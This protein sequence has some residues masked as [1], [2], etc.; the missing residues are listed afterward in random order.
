[1]FR[2]VLSR[3]LC[4]VVGVAFFGLALLWV[5]SLAS[6]S[7]H[8]PGAVLQHRGRR[9]RATSAAASARSSPSSSFQLLGYAAYLLPAA[10]VVVGWH[11]FWVRA[12]HARRGPSSLGGVVLFSAAARG[13]SAIAFDRLPHRRQGRSPPA[14]CSAPVVAGLLTDQLNRTGALDARADARCSSPLLMVTQLSLGAVA[15]AIG[16]AAA[17]ARRRAG[18]RASAAGAKSGGASSSARK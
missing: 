16:G 8:R 6:Y 7:A 1:M 9:G 13:C 10:L 14:A 5:I 17:R 15:A 11:Y 3:R 12:L 4:E 18:R 2:D